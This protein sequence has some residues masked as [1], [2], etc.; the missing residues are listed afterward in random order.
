MCALEPEAMTK[1]K[2]GITFPTPKGKQVQPAPAQ[3][4][5][6]RPAVSVTR[7]VPRT[8]ASANGR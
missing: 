7:I 5:R 6:R 1:S 8:K 2:S 3:D 4:P